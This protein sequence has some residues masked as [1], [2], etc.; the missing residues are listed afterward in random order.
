MEWK[1]IQY[2][3]L[4]LHPLRAGLLLAHRLAQWPELPGHSVCLPHLLVQLAAFKAIVKQSC[5]RTFAGLGATWEKAWKH[6]NRGSLKVLHEV[7]ARSF[8]LRLSFESY[9]QGQVLILEPQL[10]NA[11]AALQPHLH[12]AMYPTDPNHG[13]HTQLLDLN[14]NLPC[15][16]RFAWQSLNWDQPCTPTPDWVWLADLSS[17]LVPGPVSS[18]WICLVLWT[19][20]WINLLSLDLVCST[21]FRYC[22][23]FPLPLRPLVLPA[24]L[25]PLTTGSSSPA[26]QPVLVAPWQ[27]HTTPHR[28]LWPPEATVLGMQCAPLSWMQNFTLLCNDKFTCDWLIPK[29]FSGV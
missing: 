20:G 12:L 1:W 29:Y 18:L 17:W 6:L 3:T 28:C 24:F 10:S 14:S 23:T 13:P 2:H 11:A 19:A 4:E 5:Q 22:R 8:Y 27:Q 16:Y 25:S 21:L 9:F 26:D 15:C 7:L